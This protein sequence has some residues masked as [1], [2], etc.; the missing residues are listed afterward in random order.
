[1]AKAK[2][3]SAFE[4]AYFQDVLNRAAGNVSEAARLSGLDRSN[5]RRAARRAGVKTRDDS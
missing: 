2:A 3:L 4:T 1:V 5:F